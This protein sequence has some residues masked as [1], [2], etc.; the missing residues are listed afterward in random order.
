MISKANAET[1]IR[2]VFPNSRISA[3]KRFKKGLVNESYS[4]S[5][6]SPKK[7]LVLRIYPKEGW[8]VEKE[9]YLYNLIKEKTNVPVPA[10][11]NIDTSKSIINKPYA[12]LSKIEGK[13]LPLSKTLVKEAGSCLAKLHSIKFGSFGWIINNQIKPKFKTWPGFILYD[14]NYKIKRTKMPGQLAAKI[15]KYVKI[16]QFL[17]NIKTKPCLL[18]KDYHKSHILVKDGRISGIID[19]EW[20]IA[21]HN[22]M[23]IVKS[24]LWMFNRNKELEKIFLD[25][26]KKYGAIS[27]KFNERRRL[28]ELI[29]YLSALNFAYELK[30]KRWYD[31]NLKRIKEA[32]ST[33]QT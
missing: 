16:N 22:E 26:Y 1:A 25:G 32:L 6:S 8:K 10:V 23:D 13:E 33:W 15:K 21:G 14:L 2:K 28:Y 4:V 24:L 12:L 7:E 11:Y 17:L 9:A 5:I 18:H 30:N 29:T 3:I 19:F 20:S 31:Y 27:D